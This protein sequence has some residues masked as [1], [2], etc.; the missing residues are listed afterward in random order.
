MGYLKK[1]WGEDKNM[2]FARPGITNA[3]V[4]G[5]VDWVSAAR[6]SVL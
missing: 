2:F 3:A 5:V 1:H 4:L 6:V